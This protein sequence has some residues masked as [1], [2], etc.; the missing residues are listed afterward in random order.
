MI[1]I[2]GFERSIYTTK[3]MSG[4]VGE[5]VRIES[6]VSNLRGVLVVVGR[7]VAALL[8]VVAAVLIVVWKKSLNVA[9]VVGKVVA[10][11]EAVDFITSG[12]FLDKSGRAFELCRRKLSASYIQC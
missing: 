4:L 7:V 11:F 5:A 8:S 12:S 3:P 9:L 1:A 10:I 6:M 2:M